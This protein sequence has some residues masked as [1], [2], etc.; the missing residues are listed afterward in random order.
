MSRTPSDWRARGRDIELLDGRIFT[1]SL[2]PPGPAAAVEP[3]MVLHGFPLSSWTFA[4]AADLLARARPVVLFDFLGFGYSAKPTDGG[5]SVF[6]Q[7]DLTVA[8]ARALG[9]TRVHVW[10][11]DMGASVATEL[12]ARRERGLLP[13]DI[14]SLMLMAGG[15]YVEMSRPT[16]GQSLLMTRAGPALVRLAGDNQTIFAKQLRRTFA[17]P[18]APQVLE[19]IWS[20]HVREDGAARMPSTIRFMHDRRRF[21]QRWVGALHR[22]DIPTLIGWGSADPVTPLAVG[23]RLARETPGAELKVWPDLGHQPHLEDARQVAETAS[24]FFHRVDTAH[25]G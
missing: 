20:L 25:R 19:D 7:A 9:L 6:E 16:L 1:V 15:V 12:L 17:K 21:R 4:E 2:G 8:V 3:V 22:L 14:V 23:E 13:F 24:A 10:S 11:H 5:Y 18:P